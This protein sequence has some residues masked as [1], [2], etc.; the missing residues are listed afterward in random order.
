MLIPFSLLL[1][2]LLAGTK[3]LPFWYPGVE[4]VTLLFGVEKLSKNGLLAKGLSEEQNELKSLGCL[5]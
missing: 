2:Q 5:P 4:L 1:S 3:I